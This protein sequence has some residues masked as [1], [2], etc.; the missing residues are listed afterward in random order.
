MHEWRQ[1]QRKRIQAQSI[2][3]PA[4]EATAD[5]AVTESITCPAT[6]ATADNVVMEGSTSSQHIWRYL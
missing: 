6:E 2:T 1:R 4:T 5:N 3:Y